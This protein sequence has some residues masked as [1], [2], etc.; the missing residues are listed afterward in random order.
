MTKEEALAFFGIDTDF[1]PI[2]VLDLVDEHLFSIKN[3]VLQK[4]AVPALLKRRKEKCIQVL[5]AQTALQMNE[6][7]AIPQFEALGASEN[8]ILFLEK[9]ERILSSIKL[10]IFNAKY[11]QV[12]IAAIDALERLQLEYG[13]QFQRCFN[14]IIISDENV[15][16]AESI[17]TGVLLRLLKTDRASDE[18]NQLIGK[19]LARLNKLNSLG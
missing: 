2:E 3:E 5:E 11:P 17:D 7:V 9:Y 19:E 6:D 8:E 1:Q 18:A 10:S 15:P 14:Q 12:L 4:V 16:A 13:L